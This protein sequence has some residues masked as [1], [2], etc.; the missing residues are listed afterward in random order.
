MITSDAFI[1]ISSF[2]S[3]KY[4]SYYKLGPAQPN[5]LLVPFIGGGGA[6]KPAES[7]SES[8]EEKVD[9]CDSDKAIDRGEVPDDDADAVFVLRWVIL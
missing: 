5:P 2:S 3:K 8:D 6:R 9:L 1:R 4:V 7:S